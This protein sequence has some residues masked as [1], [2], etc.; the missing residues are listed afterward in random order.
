M[1]KNAFYFWILTLTPVVLSNSLIRL[2]DVLVETI[3]FSMYTVIS[4][5]N[6][7]SFTP[8]FP[9][10]MP[11]ISFSCPIVVARTFNTM[12]NRSSESGHPFL[13]PNLS[14]KPVSF[15]PLSMMLAVGFSYMAF[16]VLGFASSTPTLLSVFNH[17]YLLTTSWKAVL[18]CI[19]D[20]YITGNYDILQ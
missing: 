18:V 16:T 17:I 13:V 10:W 5:A 7:D 11:F 6:S 15:Y 2:S 8:S 20:V 1:Y 19:S 14:G 4:S 3:G 12:L 9:I